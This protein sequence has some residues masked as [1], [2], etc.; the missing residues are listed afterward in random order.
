MEESN[1]EDVENGIIN[2]GKGLVLVGEPVLVKGKQTIRAVEERKESVDNF[3]GND[4]ETATTT[5]TS[6]TTAQVKVLANE[7]KESLLMNSNIYK[8]LKEELLIETTAKAD[9]AMKIAVEAKQEAAAAWNEVTRVVRENLVATVDE[10]EIF[11]MQDSGHPRQSNRDEKKGETKSLLSEDSYT[12]MMIKAPF[13]KSWCLG[14]AIFI[15]QIILLILIFQ[16]ELST[17]KNSTIFDV[18]FQV[19]NSVRTGQ[20]LAIFISIL[21]SHDILMPIKDL[22]LLWFTKL[23]WTKIVAEIIE[24]QQ[25]YQSLRDM[26]IPSQ[27]G[28]RAST[29]RSK[30]WTTQIFF[31]SLLKFIQGVFVLIITFV[32]TIKSD[33]IIDLFK[34]LAATQVISELDNVVFHLSNHGYFGVTLRKDTKSAKDIKVQD[35]VQVV[36]FGLSLRPIMLWGLLFVMIIIFVNGIVI[37]QMNGSFFEKKYP[38]CNIRDKNEIARMGNGECNGG[39]PNTFQC[40][41]D[42]GDCLDFNIAF[43]NCKAVKAY[44]VGDGECQDEHNDESFGFDGGDCCVENIEV[45]EL[46]GDGK[47]NA[48]LYNSKICLFDKGDCD[49]FR[50]DHPLC[51]DLDLT[52]DQIYRNDGTP[53]VIGDG[54]CDFIPQYMTDKC[55]YEYGDCLECNVTDPTKL[56]DG[57]CDGGEYNTEGCGFDNGDC[58]QCN[59]FVKNYTR[60]GDGN[61]DGGKYVSSICNNDGGDCADCINIVGFENTT[62]FVGNGICDGGEFMAP[63]CGNDGRDCDGCVVTNPFL[64]GNDHCDGGAYNTEACEFDGGDCQCINR[65]LNGECDEKPDEM[66]F[67]CSA[68]CKMSPFLVVRT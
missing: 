38:N 18:P 58:I 68:S 14:F 12:L 8:Q 57:I 15:I 34:D 10:R 35:K 16:G 36:C 32:I 40:G 54:K 28:R 64:I 2:E 4:E 53:I 9:E 49:A 23:E 66:L 55:G 51:P 19:S 5:T 33:N 29:S 20:F 61:C 48:G 13:T 63:E 43:P 26:E 45:K 37:G 25:Y 42:G 7:E 6:R 44:Q 27:Q 21:I 30:L 22:N 41:F 24:R 59:K 62:R 3:F 17:S 67:T 65:V 31:P 60:V 11:A 46:L 47:C 52:K 39:L 56:G 50:N 1:E